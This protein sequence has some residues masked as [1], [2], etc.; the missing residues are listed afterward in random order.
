MRVFVLLVNALAIKIII[1]PA[2]QSLILFLAGKMN[3]KTKNKIYMKIT[4]EMSNKYDGAKEFIDNRIKELCVQDRILISE[5][6]IWFKVN[7]F[8]ALK[9]ILCFINKLAN[10][11]MRIVRLILCFFILLVYGIWSGRK[12]VVQNQ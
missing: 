8:F 4:E 3:L 10:V 9:V 6:R 12:R 1:T 2:L 11:V 5:V 7:L